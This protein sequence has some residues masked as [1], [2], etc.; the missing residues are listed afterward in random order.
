MINLISYDVLETN[1]DDWIWKPRK[2]LYSKTLHY[3]PYYGFLCRFDPE[4]KDYD[5]YI[6]LSDDEIKKED[7]KCRHTDRN[8]SGTIKLDVSGIWDYI[9]DFVTNINHKINITLVDKDDVLEIYKL[10][11]NK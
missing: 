8:K 6:V 3:K 10:N 4:Y 11:F 7:L 5:Y 9:S 2:T 1:I